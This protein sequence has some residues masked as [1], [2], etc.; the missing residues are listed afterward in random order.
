MRCISI[1][2]L[3]LMCALL[4]AGGMALGAQRVHLRAT[5]AVGRMRA[6]GRL[7]GAERLH[8]ALALRLRDEAGL[9]K[10]LR[11]LSDPRSPNYR[12]YLTR[13]QFAE[14]YGPTA[15]DYSAVIAYAK[16]QG[17]TTGAQSPNRLIL[18]VQGTVANIERALHVTMRTYRRP[19]E[20]RDFYA[21]DT[22]PSL[23]LAVPLAGIEG[24]DNYSLPRPRLSRREP[25]L[26]GGRLARLAPLA[27][28]TNTRP[29]TGSGPGG[30]Y[31]GYDFRAAYA[32]DTTLT[33]SGQTI[34][35]LQ[36][37]GFTPA[38]IA[39]Y[40]TAAGL[41]SVTPT[42]VLLDGFNGQPTGNG[43][44]V[45]VSLDIEMAISMAP[46]M[47]ALVVYEAGPNGNWYDLLNRMISDDLANQISC[48]WYNPDGPAD[49]TA[50]A[51]FQEMSAQGQ[52]FISAS[53]DSDAYTGLIPFPSDSPYITKAGGTTLTVSGTGGPYSSETVWNWNNGKGSGGGISTQ[54]AIPA[55]QQGFSMTAA[56]GS[57]TM[58]NV[59]DIAMVADNVYVRADG[60]DE[61]VGGTSCAAPLWAAFT[62][63]AN[64][65]AAANHE[66]P[67]GFLN[68]ALYAIA[69]GTGYLAAFHDIA[70]G[71]NF[72]ASS[73]AEFS[74]VAGYDLCTGLGSPAGMALID[75]L[76]GTP[77]PEITTGPLL[78]NGAVGAAYSQ[79]LAATG[80]ESPYAWAI[81]SGAAP[82]GLS[83]SD[84]GVLNGTP[85][86]SGSF[87]FTVQVAGSNGLSSCA[88]FI[89]NI[90]AQGTPIITTGNALV[91]A[92]LGVAYSEQLTATGGA[93]PYAWAIVSGSAPAGL[94]LGGAGLLSGTPEETGTFAF[95]VQV[96]GSDGLASATPFTLVAPAPPAITGS[97]AATGTNGVAF[98]YQIAAT[99]NPASYSAS[100]LPGGLDIDPATGEI[101]GTPEATG[102]STVTVTASNGGGM[103]SAALV[104]CIVQ[105]PAPVIQCALTTVYAFSGGD[106]Q[107]PIA[108]LALGNDGNYYGTTALGGAGYGTVFQLTPA[109]TLTTIAQF[110]SVNGYG[111]FG[112]LVQ[113]TNGNFYGTTEIGGDSGNGNVFEVTPG[114]SVTSLA[115]FEQ[116]NGAY[117]EA[118]LVQAGDGNFYGTTSMNNIGLGSV[119]QITPSGTLTSLFEF[120]YADGYGP[121]C[122]LI[123]GTDGNLY[124]T[125]QIGGDFDAGVVF[126]ITTGGV[127]NAIG[128][129]DGENGYA[130][131]AGV[132]QGQ[133]GNYYGATYYG[134]DIGY[135]AV[136]KMTPGGA[137]T[138][139]CSFDDANG[140]NP[141]SGL[142]QGMDGNFYGTTC[143][144]GSGAG[145]GTVFMVTASGSLTT[146]YSFSGPDGAEPQGALIQAANGTLFGTTNAGGANDDGIVFGIAPLD[147]TVTVGQPFS[148]QIS[149][150]SIAAPVYG[151]DGLPGW[152]NLDPSSGIL[153]GTPAATGTTSVTLTATN[154]G[155]TG[156]VVLTIVVAPPPPVITSGSNG[157][158]TV[159]LPF[160][161]QITA[162]NC[163]ARFAAT[164][165]P[166]GLSLDAATGLISGTAIATGTTSVTVSAIN[167]SGSG[168]EMVSMVITPLSFA[169]WQ[170]AWFTPGQSS[171][172][173]DNAE[174]A[175]DGI[176]NLLKYAFNVDPFVSGLSALPEQGFIASGGS[177]YLTLTYTQSINASD[178]S[179]TPQV[180]TDLRAWVS[181]ASSI[182]TV[183]V[184]PNRDGVTETVVVQDLAPAGSGPQFMR[185]QVTGP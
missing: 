89:L 136:F 175:G 180:S 57:A 163:P 97:L 69:S 61:S 170:S 22:D 117:P 32:P 148:F 2:R 173:G 58:Q 70:T 174:P 160:S 72:S 24:L 182:G 5:D 150:I 73:P 162:S 94:S 8:L 153:S 149:A 1:A 77:A 23:D 43:G 112:A 51:L 37:D 115:S 169:A 96:T 98:A 185:L 47:A 113:G 44:E 101:Y 109:G 40:E 35:L 49:P 30:T 17:L 172:S 68:P 125:T 95:T 161:Y 19:R 88:A 157:S 106:G 93:L 154:P 91:T 78:S 145:M 142:I 29:S 120:D 158:G 42:N 13:A 114:G 86:E 20:H 135:G 126:N 166:A 139:L 110:D 124:G 15:G 79:T 127:E 48:S 28:A 90:Y 82:A 7:D 26:A 74:A 25:L 123:Q 67:V 129:F 140:A 10:F 54:Y 105:M 60:Q 64:Q 12:H 176:A 46:G 62:A 50:D 39:Y 41:P 108:P 121:T 103:A 34:G 14:R 104:I 52:T 84:A 53:G 63:L 131:I 65:E 56:Q 184:T 171:I 76:A 147:E 151:A 164:G 36:F 83:L 38:D 146:L 179:Y 81:I 16:A 87:G 167:A 118:G 85:E 159:A 144:G 137:I 59:P 177:N 75:A 55:W 4:C 21:P 132:I 99:N 71:N 31:M 138:A 6:T 183:S 122:E 143:F 165:L 3:A 116:S 27:T 134:G 156:T 107:N 128:N 66:K 33:G 130:P 111:P 141:V 100:G 133:D 102:T 152:L 155:G 80:G 92:T 119:F 178:L 168:S 181:G 18:D 11:E 9:A 45:E